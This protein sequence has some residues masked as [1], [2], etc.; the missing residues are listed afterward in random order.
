M[1][2][3]FSTGSDMVIKKAKSETGKVVIKNM[4]TL[5]ST[6]TVIK[7]NESYLLV[8]DEDSNLTVFDQRTLQKTHHFP[9]IHLDCITSIVDLPYK[10]KYHFLSSG[11]T[12]VA[13][14]DIRKGVLSQSDDQE[15]E[16]LCGCLSSEKNSVFGMSEGVVT[17]WENEHLEDQINRIRLSDETIDCMIAGEDDHQVF[18]GGADGV[19]RQVNVRA[20]RIEDKWIH[21]NTEEVGMLELDCDYRLV[22]ASMETLKVW[23]NPDDD[24]D[25]EQEGDSDNEKA[26]PPKKKLKRGKKPAKKQIQ[27]I[28]S[29]EGL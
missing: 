25:S 2:V 1:Q 27:G 14:I 22:S 12:T 23:K 17:I 16:I 4:D 8:G 19:V 28:T 20:S 6:P 10:N 18:A 24:Q 26:K 9:N 29:F 5:Q 11:A 7:V 3:I 13:H 15:D 21:S